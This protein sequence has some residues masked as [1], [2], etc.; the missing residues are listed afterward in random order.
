MDIYLEMAAFEKYELDLNQG[1]RLDKLLEKGGLKGRIPPKDPTIALFYAAGPPASH[2]VL[3]LGNIFVRYISPHSFGWNSKTG[4]DQVECV[5]IA[6]G[7]SSQI[8]S[9]YGKA[10]DT[11]VYF[12]FI[13]LFLYTI[14]RFFVGKSKKAQVTRLAVMICSM[15]FLISCFSL[16]QEMEL[17]AFHHKCNGVTYMYVRAWILIEICAFLMNIGAAFFTLIVYLLLERLCPWYIEKKITQEVFVNLLKD[18]ENFERT[19]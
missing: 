13:A 3:L 10:M 12:H 6:N 18:V 4:K 5:N 14:E 2:F 17:S 9:Q 8:S 19:R 7:S 11:L 15:S 16:F 1:K